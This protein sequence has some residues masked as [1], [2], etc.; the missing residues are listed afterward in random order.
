MTE[1]VLTLDLT[2]DQVE[3]ALVALFVLDEVANGTPLPIEPLLNRAMRFYD[4][5][6]RIDLRRIGQLSDALF[7]PLYDARLTPADRLRMVD[8]DP[9]AASD[10]E[11]FAILRDIEARYGPITPDDLDRAYAS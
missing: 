10:E 2:T 3:L 5:R 6:R 4:V 9:D 8:I 11:A 7:G 1:K